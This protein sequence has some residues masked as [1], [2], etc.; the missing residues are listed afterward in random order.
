MTA[1]GMIQA[2]GMREIRANMRAVVARV[3]AGEA[4]VVLRDGQPTAVMLAFGEAQRWQQ[5][6]RGLSALHG[7]ELYPELARDT[8]ELARLVRREARPAATAVRRLADQPRDILAPLRTMG[9]TDARA[10][11]AGLLDEITGGR[12]LT[13]VASGRFAATLVAPR[14]FDR[15]RALDRTVGW[16]RAAGLDLAAADDQAIAAFVRDFAARPAASD[17]AAA[18]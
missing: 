6:E 9:I 11:F 4:L 1:G 5:I 18:G 2:L 7:L 14:E 12:T 15:L 3:E 17:V 8:A 10:G 13:I 16:F